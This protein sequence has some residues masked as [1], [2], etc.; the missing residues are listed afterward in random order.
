M[1][2]NAYISPTTQ[3][4][5]ARSQLIAR[6][7]EVVQRRYPYCTLKTFGSTAHDLYLPDGYENHRIYVISR[8]VTN[9][10]TPSDIDMCV[11][12]P[13]EADHSTKVKMLDALSIALRNSQLTKST[14]VIRRARVPLVSFQTI[15]ELG[16]PLVVL[17]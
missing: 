12:T 17:T 8:M 2:Y 13:H 10:A 7:G 5:Y 3:E 9:V 16:K 11:N 1:A 6:I 4:I 14:F 15:T